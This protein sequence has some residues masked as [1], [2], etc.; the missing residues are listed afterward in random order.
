MYHKVFDVIAPRYKDRKGGCT[1]ILLLGCRKG[2]ATEV[3]LIKL[4]D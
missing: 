4:V 2:D 1:R 3:A